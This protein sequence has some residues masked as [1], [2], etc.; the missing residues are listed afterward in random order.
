MA[1]V[2]QVRGGGQPPESGP[3]DD[4]AHVSPTPSSARPPTSDPA[5]THV[6]GERDQ[7]GRRVAF[8]LDRVERRDRLGRRAPRCAA[9]APSSA[10]ESTMACWMS[11]T[12]PSSRSGAP[13][14]SSTAS[15]AGV[16]AATA[17]ASSGV[18]L[19]SRRSPPTGLPVTRL[20]AERA[21]HV[22]AHLERVAERQAVGAE[23]GEERASAGRA[24]RAPRRGG[25]AARWCTCRSCS[26]R[27]ARPVARSRTRRTEPRMSSS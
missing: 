26:D 8:E 1:A 14:R 18:G 20:V 17:R 5:P 16:A 25:A 3:D 2:A 10:P 9:R 4:D 7:L 15:C 24:R 6:V 23:A 27:S 11:A 22:V 12:S 19:P 13:T 21:H